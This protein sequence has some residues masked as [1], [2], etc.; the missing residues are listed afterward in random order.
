M[1][2]LAQATMVDLFRMCQ[3]ARPDEIEQYKAFIGS[4]WN[5]ENVVNDLFNRGGVKWAMM[6]DRLPFCVG[7]WEPLI[8]GVWQGW[9]VG[10]MDNWGKYWRSI[11]KLCRQSVKIMFA[12][13]NTRRLQIGVLASREKTCE[14]YI[15]GMQFHYESTMKNFGLRGEDMAIYV[16]F[17]E[18]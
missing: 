9:M 10:T 15:R 11:T 12:L 18:E 17:R 14:W 16:K 6:D 7:G 2:Y 5:V 3:D 1:T 4:D 13:E 8:E